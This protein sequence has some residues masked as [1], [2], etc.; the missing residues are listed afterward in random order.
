VPIVLKSGSFNLLEP[1]GPVQA[2]NAAAT[3][4]LVLKNSTAKT[5]DPEYYHEIKKNEMNRAR[6]TYGGEEKCMRGFGG[7]NLRKRD[8][9]DDPGIDGRIILRWIFRKWV[10]GMDWIDLAQ[11]WDIWRAF[12]ECGH[13]HSGSIKCGEFLD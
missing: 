5:V 2:C 3:V 10:V 9:L 1:S 13:E 11:D 8:H 6:S 4:I 7:G 12:C